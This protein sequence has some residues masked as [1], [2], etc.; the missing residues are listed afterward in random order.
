MAIRANLFVRTLTASGDPIKYATHTTAH[1][2]SPLELV[3]HGLFVMILNL[4]SFSCLKCEG[5]E[6]ELHQLAVFSELHAVFP[7]VR[8]HIDLVG[9]AVPEER[10]GCSPLFIF[11]VY[12]LFTAT[13]S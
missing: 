3:F 10:F 9:P 4:G 12:L 13:S 11:L 7:D 8:I 5:P 6:K 1:S 2:S